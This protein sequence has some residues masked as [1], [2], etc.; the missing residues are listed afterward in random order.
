MLIVSY[1]FEDNVDGPAYLQ[2]LRDFFWPIIQ[3][4]GLGEDIIFMQD[5]APPHWNKEVRSWLDE[6]W[7]ER[8]MGHSSTNLPWLPRSPDLTPSDY[9]FGAI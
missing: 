8:W 7:P 4:K 1:F 5:V 2:M 6:T 9:F 3:A